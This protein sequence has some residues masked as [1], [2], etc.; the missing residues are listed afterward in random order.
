MRREVSLLKRPRFLA[1]RTCAEHK[2]LWEYD[3]PI[4]VYMTKNSG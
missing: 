2:S 4:R 1:N 3:M